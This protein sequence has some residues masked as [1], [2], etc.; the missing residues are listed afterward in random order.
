MATLTISLSGQTDITKTLSASD[1]TKLI[2]AFTPIF[3]DQGIPSPTNE[4]LFD[5]WVSRWLADT[6][7]V[8]RNRQRV[9]ADNG[10]TPVVFT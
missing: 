7:T 8:I 4:Q 5:Y 2:D 1:L 10:I 6:I 3:Q 9:V